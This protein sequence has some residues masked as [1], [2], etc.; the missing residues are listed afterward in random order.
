MVS[1]LV[2][3]TFEPTLDDFSM[4]WTNPESKMAN[5]DGHHSEMITQLLRHVTS[6]PHDVDVKGHILRQTI[7]PQGLVVLS[8]IFSELRRG[9][10]YARRD[11]ETGL[12]FSA[13]LSV[14]CADNRYIQKLFLMKSYNR[15]QEN[16]V[17]LSIKSITYPLNQ[18]KLWILQHG[19]SLYVFRS[20]VVS[21]SYMLLILAK[22]R[23]KLNL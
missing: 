11:L 12:V 10:D 22:V 16:M 6:L 3:I 14:E 2:L 15:I 13:F 9:W 18:F 4:L 5:K 21:L 23:I 1:L 7:Y 20:I 8:S 19:D 17:L